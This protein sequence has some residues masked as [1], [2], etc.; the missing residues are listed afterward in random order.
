MQHLASILYVLAD[1]LRDSMCIH[2]S[3]KPSTIRKPGMPGSQINAR[4]GIPLFKQAYLLALR[5]EC[6]LVLLFP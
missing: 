2:D 5:A 4:E 6:H 1:N 3:C